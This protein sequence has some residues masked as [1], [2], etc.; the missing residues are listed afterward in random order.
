M[1]FTIARI[2]NDRKANNTNIGSIICLKYN[3][4]AHA[5]WTTKSHKY[6]EESKSFIKFQ[7]QETR[8][9]QST[10]KESHYN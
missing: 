9:I 8:T 6:N 4:Q 7:K 3:F 1:H 5:R 10:L 2:I